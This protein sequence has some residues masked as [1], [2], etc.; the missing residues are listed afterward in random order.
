MLIARGNSTVVTLSSL[1]QGGGKD[2]NYEKGC[3]TG[4]EAVE[5]NFK[6]WVSGRGKKEKIGSK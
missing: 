1:L 4:G 5:G 6:V 2:N 3:R